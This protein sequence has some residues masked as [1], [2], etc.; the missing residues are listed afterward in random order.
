VGDY[1]LPP[2]GDVI[3]TELVNVYAVVDLRHR[4]PRQPSLSEVV[5]QGR[6][7]GIASVNLTDVMDA[8]VPLETRSVEDMGNPPAV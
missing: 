6:R 3:E 7:L 4:V 5:E 2:A 1:G 8:D